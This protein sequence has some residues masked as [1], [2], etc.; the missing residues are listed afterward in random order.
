MYLCVCVCVVV[1]G[2]LDNALCSTIVSLVICS[3]SEEVGHDFK[4]R[5]TKHEQQCWPR[6]T[7]QPNSTQLQPDAEMASNT[8]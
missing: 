6:I 1:T 3:N 5:R 2:I 8:F 7:L 4:P